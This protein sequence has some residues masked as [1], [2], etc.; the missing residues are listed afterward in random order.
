MKVTLKEFARHALWLA[1]LQPL[2]DRFRQRRG[3]D[4]KLYELPTLRDRFNYIYANRTWP[5]S[6]NPDA[7]LSGWG[8]SLE[9][10]SSLREGLPRLL[11]KIGAHSIVDAGCGDFT[12]MNTISLHQ[13]YVGVD[14]VESVIEENRKRYPEHTFVCADI[15]SDPLPTADVILCREVLFHLSFADISRFVQNVRSSGAQFLLAT[16]DRSTA[17]N[18][19]ISP[20]DFRPVNLERRP[21]SL[22]TPLE[23]IDDSHIS[24]GRLLGLWRIADLEQPRRAFTVWKQRQNLA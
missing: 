21:F 15:T 24:S 2:T 23:T 3:H 1:G 6:N 9:A 16:S 7:P 22:V 14:L 4:V 18:A 17:V 13:K 5:G 11:D 20:G 8:S 19:D 10:T 12:W